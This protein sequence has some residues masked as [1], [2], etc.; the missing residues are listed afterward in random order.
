MTRKSQWRA[1]AGAG[2]G[3]G[4]PPAPKR[5]VGFSLIELIVA[6]A[7]F[8]IV[9]GVSFTL[10]S[11]HESL[12]SQEQGIA[13]LNIGLRNA[14]SQLQLDVVNAG[15]GLILG[16]NVPAWPVGVTIVN[17]N[18]SGTLCNPTATNPSTYVAACFDQLN[19][20]MVDQ[21]TPAVHP[22]TNTGGCINTNTGTTLYGAFP[23]GY[24]S[25]TYA[26]NFVN[27]D[28]VLFV[29]STGAQITT[30]LLSAAGTSTTCTSLTGIANCSTNYPSGF[31]SLTFH[32]TG[33][34]GSNTTA[35]DPISMTVNAPSTKLTNTFCSTDWVLRLLPIQYSVS[36]ATPT[37][38]QL[39]RTQG[40]PAVQNIV[41][42]QVI[43]FKVG[44]AYWSNGNVFAMVSTNG[45][46]VTWVSGSTFVTGGTW[47][48]QQVLIN[49]VPYTVSSVASTTSLTLTTSA[50]VQASVNF[51]GPGTTQ[52]DFTYDYNTADFGSDFTLVRAV[53]ATLIGRTVPSTDPTYTYENP[54]DLGHYQIRG[55]SIIVNPRNLTMNND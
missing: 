55:S 12:L 4:N 21:N 22:M 7:I 17:N 18:I 42:D 19:V 5:D 16:A 54:F 49:N 40:N 36:V 51:S 37:D 13:G 34:G 41:M 23:S 24:S 39:I 44:A 46:T 48:G 53:R 47:S 9:G 43:G 11:R 27:G 8:M 32:S 28:Q 31:A 25:S 35:N 52:L 38:P 45:T 14:L 29:T 10:F 20:V 6:M 30:A 50:G 1:D 15:D 33:A 3:R 2:L 26:A